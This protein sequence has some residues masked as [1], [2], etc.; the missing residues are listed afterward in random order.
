MKGGVKFDVTIESTSEFTRNLTEMK[1]FEV[2]CVV[3]QPSD[4]RFEYTYL[5]NLRFVLDKKKLAANVLETV[6]KDRMRMRKAKN[7]KNDAQYC[8]TLLASCRLLDVTCQI[9]NGKTVSFRS[10]HDDKSSHLSHHN[11][12]MIRTYLRCFDQNVLKT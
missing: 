7:S 11:R 10:F 12:D 5:R 2:L 4:L 9:L 6:K 1:P 3:P 8:K